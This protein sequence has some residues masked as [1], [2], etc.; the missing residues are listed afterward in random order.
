MTRTAGLEG[1]LLVRDARSGDAA[2]CVAVYAP[3]VTGTAVTFELQPPGVEEM[4]ARIAGWQQTHAWLVAEFSGRVVGYAY[5]HPFADR[6]AYRFAC[7]STVYVDPAATGR[8]VGRRLSKVLLDRLRE[9]GMRSVVARVVTPNAASEALHARLGYEHVGTLR[10]IGWKHDT[11]HDV[12]LW[13][14]VLDP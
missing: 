14:L 5:A 4:A 8:G 1:D 10:R 12:A 13:Q 11:W 3:F 7:E 6:P 9:R 2:A